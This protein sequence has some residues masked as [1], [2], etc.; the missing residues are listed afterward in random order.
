MLLALRISKP[1]FKELLNA[2]EKMYIVAGIVGRVVL[3]VCHPRL[4]ENMM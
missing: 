2:F 3:D 1:N 4:C